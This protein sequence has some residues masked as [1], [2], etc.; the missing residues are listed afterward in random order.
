M[1]RILRPDNLKKGGVWGAVITAIASL[2]YAEIQR[3]ENETLLETNTEL[4]RMIT[5]EAVD[6]RNQ[7]VAAYQRGKDASQE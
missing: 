6:C 7:I 2:G 5:K 1:K 3:E 4:V